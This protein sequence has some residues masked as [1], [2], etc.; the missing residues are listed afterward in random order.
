MIS[1]LLS[2]LELLRREFSEIEM[3]ILAGI[4][5]DHDGKMITKS[6]LLETLLEYHQFVADRWRPTIEVLHAKVQMLTEEG[7]S[8][9][10]AASH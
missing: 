1:E 9:L 3:T 10:I 8:M 5:D 6:I 4:A 2:N 7:V